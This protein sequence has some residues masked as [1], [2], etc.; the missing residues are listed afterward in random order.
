MILTI[1][2]SVLLKKS[3]HHFF[4]DILAS[5]ALTD[6]SLELYDICQ[7]NSDINCLPH[8]TKV[9]LIL[10]DVTHYMLVSVDPSENQFFVVVKSSTTV[11]EV[12]QRGWDQDDH[13]MVQKFIQ[14]CI[15]FQLCIQGPYR[16][17]AMPT[18]LPAVSSLGT[19]TPDS[20]FNA[21]DYQVYERLCDKFLCLPRGHLALLTR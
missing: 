17:T 21:F 12:I 4:S 18:S 15:P 20:R 10:G 6:I 5:K 8:N 2:L 1:C 9:R 16:K 14:R 13:L 19:R 7:C 3:L 11:V